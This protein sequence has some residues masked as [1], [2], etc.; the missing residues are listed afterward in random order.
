M[1]FQMTA[2]QIQQFPPMASQIQLNNLIQTHRDTL[3]CAKMLQRALSL[4]LMIQ[5]TFCSAVWCLMVFYILLMGFT[6]KILNVLL[7]LLLLTYETY[8]YCQ[9][10]T[11]LTTKANQ[12]LDALEQLS[13]Y[14]QTV[15][16]QKQILFIIQR[17]QKPIVLTA[18]KLFPVNI[19]Q[20]SEI[21]K[22]SYSFYLVLKDV[23]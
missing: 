21:V 4:A 3:Q 15:L 8:S 11:K 20:F 5:L 12:V 7:L 22:K 9:F 2:K 16:I 10:G 6:L 19:A 18:G 1:L 14:D 13:L 23:F 17:S